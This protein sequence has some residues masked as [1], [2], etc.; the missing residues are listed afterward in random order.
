M[1]ADMYLLF[2][3]VDCRIDSVAICGCFFLQ[4]SDYIHLGDAVTTPNAKRL[5]FSCIQHTI[6]RFLT[7]GPRTAQHLAKLWYIHYI[8]V[9]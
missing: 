3:T 1:I 6:C 2:H 5:D 9:F 8:G 4:K 7:H